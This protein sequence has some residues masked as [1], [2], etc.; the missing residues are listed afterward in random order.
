MGASSL[1]FVAA[2]SLACAA[3]DL[4]GAFVPRM[5]VGIRAAADA[6]ARAGREGRDPGSVERRQVLV[7]GCIAAFVAGWFL[8]GFAGG[9]IGATAAP[10]CAN[11]VIRARHARYRAAVGV[12]AADIAV[13]LADALSGGHSLRG[14]VISAARSLAGAPGNELRRGAS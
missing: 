2:A 8:F 6:F 3:L 11:R 1:A 5:P 4:A 10:A 7:A 13:A 12:G 14:A 9:V